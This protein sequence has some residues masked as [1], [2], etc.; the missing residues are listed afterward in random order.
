MSSL[1]GDG[2]LLGVKDEDLQPRG[3]PP[4]L[5]SGWHKGQIVGSEYK[6]NNART[7]RV[8]H[9]DLRVF[10]TPN[11]LRDWLNL[12]NQNADAQRIALATLKKIVLAVKH[13]D[14]SNVADSTMLHK[15]DLMIHVQK[16]QT[17]SKYADDEGFENEISDYRAVD[18]T[19][20][21]AAPTPNSEAPADLPASA[22]PF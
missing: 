6:E 2:N 5:E 14:P 21:A 19:E 17:G 4:A 8:L 13:E 9:L 1:N 7:G 3:R 18:E 15:R 20:P 10:G 12:R 16:V 11:Y 22:L